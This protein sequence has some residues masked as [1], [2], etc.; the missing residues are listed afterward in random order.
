MSW[1]SLGPVQSLERLRR[2][3]A[4]FHLAVVPERGGDILSVV[5][6][7]FGEGLPLIRDW[8]GQNY[9]FCGYVSGFRKQ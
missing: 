4:R 2:L 9:Q 7:G 3:R 5:P 6:D 1:E 8:V